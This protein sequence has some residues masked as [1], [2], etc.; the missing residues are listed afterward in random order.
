[1]RGIDEEAWQFVD[2]SA[3]PSQIP[4]ERT[5]AQ[6]PREWY[7]EL[8]EVFGPLFRGLWF[9]SGRAFG[10]GFRAL[11]SVPRRLYGLARRLVGEENSILAV[12]LSILLS[13]VIYSVLL[14][15]LLFGF[16]W[17]ST[18]GKILELSGALRDKDDGVRQSASE[19]MAMMGPPAIPSLTKAIRDDDYFVRQSAGEA[20]AKMGPTA[21]PSLIE[22]LGDERYDVRWAAIESLG[23]MGPDAKSAIPALSRT[24]REDQYAVLRQHARQALA[25]IQDKESGGTP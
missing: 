16:R 14:A 25:N 20:L 8:A 2:K 18:A 15:A 23:K 7:Q 3:Q 17:L 6:Q 1:M 24:L 19:A 22:A 10:G 4:A 13:I 5:A 9:L 11:F 21:I 12:F